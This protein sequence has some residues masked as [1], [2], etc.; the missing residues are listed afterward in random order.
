MKASRCVRFDH[1]A[2]SIHERKSKETKL[3]WLSQQGARTTMP[4]R[5]VW[6]C[7]FLMSCS[8]CSSCCC[9]AKCTCTMNE[10]SYLDAGNSKASSSDTQHIHVKPKDDVF[11]SRSETNNSIKIES[12]SGLLR[13]LLSGL[14]IFNDSRYFPQAL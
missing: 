5:F 14:S 2:K 13:S 7:L 6:M 1:F 3:Y 10:S 8:R 12:S 11:E 4:T 9:C